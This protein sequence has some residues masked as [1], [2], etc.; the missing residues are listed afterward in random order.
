MAD[1]DNPLRSKILA[2]NNDSTLSDAEK[3][4]K[5]QELMCGKWLAPSS[6]SAPSPGAWRHLAASLLA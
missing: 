6:P 3:A 4:K 1:P 5:R 2:I